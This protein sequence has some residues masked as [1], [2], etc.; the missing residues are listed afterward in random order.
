MNY[1]L[2][3]NIKHIYKTGENM[4]KMFGMPPIFYIGYYIFNIHIIF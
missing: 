4:V 1:V 2:L 3:V